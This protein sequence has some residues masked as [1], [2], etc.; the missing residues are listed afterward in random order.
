MSGVMGYQTEFRSVL[1]IF[2]DRGDIIK[3]HPLIDLDG[4]EFEQLIS[5]LDLPPHPLEEK[6]YGSVGCMH[7]TIKGPGRNGRWM[8]TGETECG[9][10]TTYF[11][12][13]MEKKNGIDKLKAS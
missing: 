7:C 5:E 2:E 9:L 8:A 3:F 12:K 4:E 1:Q 6:G 13:K 11:L 10:H